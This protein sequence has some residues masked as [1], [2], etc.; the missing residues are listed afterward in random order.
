MASNIR[1][2]VSLVRK[3]PY[4]GKGSG[5]YID[6]THTDRELAGLI[7]E[8]IV[9]LHTSGTAVNPSNVIGELTR[10]ENLWREADDPKAFPQIDRAPGWEQKIQV[11]LGHRHPG[12]VTA[13][14]EEYE[15]LPPWRK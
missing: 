11:D 10:I 2:L 9:N 6:E 15:Q 4:L 1:Q 13:T 7:R 14:Q 8:V 3:D 12:N 5:S